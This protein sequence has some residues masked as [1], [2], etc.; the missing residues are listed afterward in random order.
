MGLE[1]L[2]SSQ[3]PRQIKFKNNSKIKYIDTG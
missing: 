2:K 1:E 3:Y